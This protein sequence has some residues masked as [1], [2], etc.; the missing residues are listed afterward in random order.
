MPEIGCQEVNWCPAGSHLVMQV[1]ASVTNILAPL[2]DA[3]LAVNSVSELCLE[4]CVN[5]AGRAAPL[6][7]KSNDDSLV[8]LH[9]L[10]EKP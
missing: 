2:R 7:E 3:P 6:A 8:A 5:V 9:L 10:N 4:T 1:F